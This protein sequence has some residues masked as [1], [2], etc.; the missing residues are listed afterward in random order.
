[1]ASRAAS[2]SGACA[3]TML[4]KKRFSVW[5]APAPLP[6][7]SPQPRR[8]LSGGIKCATLSAAISR[9]RV[10]PQI[11]PSDSMTPPIPPIG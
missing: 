4:S 11:V 3:S 2:R 5:S 8:L 6:R 1:M 10:T 7:R 9:Q